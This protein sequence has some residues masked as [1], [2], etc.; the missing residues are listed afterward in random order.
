M[1][2]DMILKFFGNFKGKIDIGLEL[3]AFNAFST[4][5]LYLYYQ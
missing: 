4:H 5:V 2:W 3:D 1:G